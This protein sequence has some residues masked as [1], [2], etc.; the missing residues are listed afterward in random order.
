MSSDPTI[1]PACGRRFDPESPRPP[2]CARCEA[3]LSV[4]W[5][6]AVQAEVLLRAATARLPGAPAAAAHLAAR[7]RFLHNTPWARRLAGLR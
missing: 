6:V 2:V 7:A 5:R 4:Y 1:C 3:D